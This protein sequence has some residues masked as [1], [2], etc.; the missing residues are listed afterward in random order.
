MVVVRGDLDNLQSN[1]DFFLSITSS[2]VAYDSKTL[3]DRFFSMFQQEDLQREE[4]FLMYREKVSDDY[5]IVEDAE[6][7]LVGE[8]EE[9]FTGSFSFA[10]DIEEDYPD[11]EE[12]YISNTSTLEFENLNLENE[13]DGEFIS[14][15]SLE[16]ENI[17]L[18]NEKNDLYYEENNL[19]L[20]KNNLETENSE[21]DDDDFIEQSYL[22]DENINLEEESYSTSDYNEDFDEYEGE[23][24]S[25]GWGDYSNEGYVEDEIEDDSYVDAFS[26][27]DINS[28]SSNEEEEEPISWGNYEDTSNETVE[29]ENEDNFFEDLEKFN[30]SSYIETT[31][32]VEVQNKVADVKREVTEEAIEVP[33]DLRDFVK[34]YHN[35][36][37]SFALKYFSKKEIDKQLS[38]GR[39]FKR[40]NR[41]LI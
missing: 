5:A 40:K 28:S 35:C 10:E 13:N 8:E 33:K 22:E 21:Y 17:N 36:E 32:V 1:I 7:L 27:V 15:S 24:E 26:K 23:E 30:S 9:Y 37:M 12:V 25:F 19:E 38:L 18:E 29:E 39:V 31:K 2:N 3:R 11:D 6:P 16:N 41:L 14:Y 20:E 34:L 4:N